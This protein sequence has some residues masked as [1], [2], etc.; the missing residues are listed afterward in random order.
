[1][2]GIDA[3]ELRSR[4]LNGNHCFHALRAVRYLNASIDECGAA[5][6]GDAELLQCSAT[7]RNDQMLQLAAVR[8]SMANC[9]D[10]N[11]IDRKYYEATRAA[12]FA[13]DLDAQLCYL[14][15]TF[16]D[17][18]ENGHYTYTESDRS[19]YLDNAPKMIDSAMK[20]GDWRVVALLATADRFT[21]GRG[22]LPQLPGIDSPTQ[23]FKMKY[24][25][26]LG[27]TDGYADQLR[28]ALSGYTRDEG[29]RSPLVSEEVA[30]SAMAWS[31]RTYETFFAK[32]E[33]LELAPIPCGNLSQIVATQ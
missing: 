2:Q 21:T 23:A 29:D 9:G 17:A 14:Q 5:E 25:L 10:Y 12:A 7:V 26:L 1:M 20:R 31:Q 33:K 18:T 6:K 19:L 22:L 32:S 15:S 24:L 16:S 30:K 11:E 27:A 13:D 28:G 3:N 4:F 8:D